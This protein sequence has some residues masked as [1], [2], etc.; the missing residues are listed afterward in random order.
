M[1]DAT[2]MT[3]NLQ[4]IDRLPRRGLMLFLDTEKTKANTG[5]LRR[6]ARLAAIGAYDAAAVLLDLDRVEKILNSHN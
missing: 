2:V 5:S 6:K 3:G 1:T 4:R